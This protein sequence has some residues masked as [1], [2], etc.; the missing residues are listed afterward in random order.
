[1]KLAGVR[2]FGDANMEIGWMTAGVYERGG[3][4]LLNVEIVELLVATG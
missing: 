3:G 2:G 1:V 4:D